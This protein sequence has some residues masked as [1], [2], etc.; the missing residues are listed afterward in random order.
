MAEYDDDDLAVARLAWLGGGRG[1]PCWLA[2]RLTP[3][4]NLKD[5]WLI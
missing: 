5:R 4:P 2:A 3:R 1:V